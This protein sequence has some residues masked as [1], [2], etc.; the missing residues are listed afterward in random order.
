M[1]Q[2]LNNNNPGR[3]MKLLSVFMFCLIAFMTPSFAGFEG[4]NQGASL[5]LF[6]RVNCGAGVVC[7]RAKDKF[8][9]AHS[10]VGFLH[11]RV[12]ASATTITASQCGATFYNAG[13][14]EIELPEASAVIG[15]RLTFV[16]L[17]AAAFDVDPDAADQILVQTNAAGDKISNATLGNT[18]TLQAVSAS[19]WVVVGILGTW[20]DAN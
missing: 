4:M 5:K 17:N 20:T 9:V 6:S 18:I 3:V 1:L 12:L 10:G 2:V 7:S 16:T 19:Q 13:A 14:I 15:C 8:T 11:T